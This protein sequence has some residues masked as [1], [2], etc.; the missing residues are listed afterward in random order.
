MCV[1]VCVCVCVGGVSKKYACMRVNV[2][3]CVCAR[4]EGG[5]ICMQD[6][7][8]VCTSILVRCTIRHRVHVVE[9]HS[10]CTCS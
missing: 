3:V 10:I 9:A 4:G 5:Y 2:R 6:C 8:Y 1:C 7:G